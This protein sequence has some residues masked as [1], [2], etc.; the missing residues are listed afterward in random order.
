MIPLYTHSSVSRERKTHT[1]HGDWQSQ[2]QRGLLPRISE[3]RDP[4][5]CRLAFGLP[6]KRR[7][8]NSMLL[9]DCLSDWSSA[10]QKAMLLRCCDVMSIR[11]VLFSLPAGRSALK[12]IRHLNPLPE[13]KVKQRATQLAPFGSC[14][15]LASEVRPGE[16]ASAISRL[17]T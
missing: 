11:D 17:S 5:P 1:V 7:A 10:E 16:S 15:N 14:A 13:P 12:H 9:Q 3:G 6:S 8:H 4:H 2:E